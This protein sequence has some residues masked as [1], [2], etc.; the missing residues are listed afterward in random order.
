MGRQAGGH[1]QLCPTVHVRGAALR[2][3]DVEIGKIRCMHAG[4]MWICRCA[5][6]L[7]PNT[8]QCNVHS[9]RCCRAGS[10]AVL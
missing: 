10:E 7:K 2:S 1:K 3:S 4:W 8:W 9:D 5:Y 6:F